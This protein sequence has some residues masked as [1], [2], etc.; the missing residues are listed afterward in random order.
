M[1]Y[2]AHVLE[3]IHDMPPEFVLLSLYLYYVNTCEAVLT[4]L[5]GMLSYLH[6]VDVYMDTSNAHLF[7]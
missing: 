1:V 2:L 6:H 3:E 5:V 4:E 7:D